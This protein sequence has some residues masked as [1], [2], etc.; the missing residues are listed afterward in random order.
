MLAG[1][2]FGWATPAADPRNYNDKGEPIKPKARERGE[3]R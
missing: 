3:A 2:M 1:S